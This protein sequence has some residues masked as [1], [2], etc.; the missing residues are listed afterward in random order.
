MRTIRPL[1]LS[2]PLLTIVLLLGACQQSSFVKS[3]L[4]L[5]EVPKSLQQRVK[6]FEGV[7]RWGALQKMY[8]FTRHEPDEPVEIPVDLDN[9]RVTSYELASGL[10]EVD[11]LRW[12]QTAVID[13]VLQDRQVVRQLVD[14]QV[15]VSED[16]K[17]WFRE[18]PPPRFQ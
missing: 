8:I 7:V 18:N 6:Q 17:N 10:A 12:R 13:Y 2:L 4:N 14:H 3:Y 15:W 16:G 5:D 11:P 1:L 9:V